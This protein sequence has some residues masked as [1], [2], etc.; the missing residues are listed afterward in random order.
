VLLAPAGG[1]MREIDPSPRPG[2]AFLAPLAQRRGDMRNPCSP[3]LKGCV[4]NTFGLSDKAMEMVEAA[5]AEAPTVH[6][7]TEVREP[8]QRASPRYREVADPR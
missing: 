7:D 4:L 2:V 5:V 3:C 6:L 8:S 1:P